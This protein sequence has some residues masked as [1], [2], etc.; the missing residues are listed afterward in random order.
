MYLLMVE[1]FFQHCS[2]AMVIITQYTVT[3]IWECYSY[4]NVS[5]VT[6]LVWRINWSIT[7]ANCAV[8]VRSST[9]WAQKCGPLSRCTELVVRRFLKTIPEASC[10]TDYV[11]RQWRRPRKRWWHRIRTQNGRTIVNRQSPRNRKCAS[12]SR[13]VLLAMELQHFSVNIAALSRTRLL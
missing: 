7:E 2:S 4:S 6:S 9:P 13:T 10:Y 5:L 12:S 1:H 11:G 3:V 8:L